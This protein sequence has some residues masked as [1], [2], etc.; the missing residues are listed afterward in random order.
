MFLKRYESNAIQLYSTRA[1]VSTP[2][3][4]VIGEVFSLKIIRLYLLCHCCF[5]FRTNKNLKENLVIT[6]ILYLV[7]AASGMVLH[8]VLG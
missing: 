6:G 7:G 5:L 3:R 4:R 2:K 8:A 1:R